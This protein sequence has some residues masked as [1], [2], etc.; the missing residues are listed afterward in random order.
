MKIYTNINDFRYRIQK[1]L[2]AVYDDSLSYYELLSKVISHLNEMGETTNSIISSFNEISEWVMNEGLSETV[3]EKIDTLLADGSL[4]YDLLEA[5]QRVK[6]KYFIDVTDKGVKGD[7]S[8]ETTLIQ[9]LINQYDA[10]YFPAGTYR[11]NSL[12]I[13]SD[14]HIKGEFNKS[15]L[16]G[17]GTDS[18]PILRI[19]GVEGAYVYNVLFE[20]MRI[21]GGVETSIAECNYASNVT[22][23]RSRLQGDDRNLSHGCVIGNGCY[24]IDFI[25]CCQAF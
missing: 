16:Q 10:L 21:H 17:V 23:L 18:N 5:I 11:V 25:D 20:D 3:S 24:Y 22:F 4:S 7:G 13:P 9:S 15:F 14:K 6:S 1:V 19:N 12:T 8:D 2:P